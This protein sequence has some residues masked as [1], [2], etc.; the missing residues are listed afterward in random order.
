LGAA[1]VPLVVRLWAV[2]GPGVAFAVAGLDHAGPRGLDQLAQH[3]RGVAR[4]RVAALG[5][6]PDQ[7]GGRSFGGLA[8]GKDTLQ[9]GDD[10]RP[11]VSAERGHQRLDLLS[12]TEGQETG[13][14]EGGGEAPGAESVAEPGQGRGADTGEPLAHGRSPKKASWRS[15]PS[16]GTTSARSR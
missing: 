3:D 9:N 16:V 13:A 11:C 6:G 15:L 8:F 10:A 5:P 7:L 2:L 14:T 1:V 12:D 4:A